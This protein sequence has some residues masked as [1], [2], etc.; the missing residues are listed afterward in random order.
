MTGK[1]MVGFQNVC[2]ECHAPKDLSQMTGESHTADTP[3]GSPLELGD[4][5]PRILQISLVFG[6]DLSTSKGHLLRLGQSG[7]ELESQR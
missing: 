3:L 2:R 7:G 4:H 1:P 5:T 6:G